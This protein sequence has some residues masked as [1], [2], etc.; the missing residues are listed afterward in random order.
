MFS[1]LNVAFGVRGISVFTRVSVIPQRDIGA[2]WIYPFG[3][4]RCPPRF[5][6]N[7]EAYHRSPSC[8][9][10]FNVNNI[11]RQFPNLLDW[12]KSSRPDVTCL[13]ELKCTD[14]EFPAIALYK[15]RYAPE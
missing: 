4:R 6:T 3:R 9:A 1:T 10:T 11:K 8:V 14:A 12:F 7:C 15:A 13:Q 5:G 2:D